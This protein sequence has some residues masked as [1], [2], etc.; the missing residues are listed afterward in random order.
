MTQTVPWHPARRERAL[1]RVTELVLA[2]LDLEGIDDGAGGLS[3]V[4]AEQ[5]GRPS[6]R[7]P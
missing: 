2:A 6:C 4:E 5:T 7:P 1:H 3:R